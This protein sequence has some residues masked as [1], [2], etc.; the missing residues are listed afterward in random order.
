[1][2]AI[3]IVCAKYLIAVPVIILGVYFLRQPRS[4]MREMA[5]FALASLVLVYVA[6]LLAA[7]AYY[8]PRPFV[9]G[10][11]TPLIAH[12]ADNG[13]PSDHALLAAALAMVGLYWNKKLGLWLAA[14]AVVIGIARVY[15]GVHHPLD[16]AASFVIAALSTWL[17]HK[18]FARFRFK[19]AI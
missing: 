9:V 11:F 13:F 12:A 4:T 5:L 2:D 16:I 8:D 1:M 7:F 3:F 19:S 6:G 14:V 17:M 15:V 18:A 10:N